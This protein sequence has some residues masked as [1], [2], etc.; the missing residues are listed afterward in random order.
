MTSPDP[1]FRV[2]KGTAN[3]NAFRTLSFGVVGALGILLLTDPVMRLWDVTG[4]ARPW[5]AS[6][7]TITPGPGALGP[8]VKDRTTA[9]YPVTGERRVWV[10]DSSG[11]RLCD[12]ERYD[13]WEGATDRSWT[14][15]AFTE[16]CAP[17]P[18]PFRVCTSFVVQ[19][20]RGARGAFGPFCSAFDPG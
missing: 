4:R 11:L 12:S 20:P 8:L 3:F 19:S 7:L 18:E 2:P 1:L 9:A 6:S 16:G 14:F 15:D 13:A 10:E 5:I 17:P